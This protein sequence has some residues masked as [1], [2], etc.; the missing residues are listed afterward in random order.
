[1]V[2]YYCTNM[3]SLDDVFDGF[4]SHREK[5]N[6]SNIASRS[7]GAHNGIDS[8]LGLGF[9]TLFVQ[10]HLIAFYNPSTSRVPVSLHGS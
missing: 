4:D 10:D 9:S 1:M 7:D 5:R 3:S 2:N 6:G 8:S